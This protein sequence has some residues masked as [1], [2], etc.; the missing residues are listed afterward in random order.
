MHRTALGDGIATAV[1]GLVSGMGNTTYSENVSVIG[2]T[3][4][5]SVRPI[6]GAAVLAI[7]LG[8]AAPVMY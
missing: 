4:V 7:L 3:K 5:A 1:G 6:L 8:F 2:L